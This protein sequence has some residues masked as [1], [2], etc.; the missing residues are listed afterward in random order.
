MNLEAA[1]GEY[2][3]H[4]ASASAVS[5][6][7]AFAGLAA[8]WI[9][10][11]TVAG[12]DRVPSDLVPAAAF[13]VTALGCDLLQYIAATAFWGGFRRWKEWERNRAKE[14]GTKFVDEF[15]AP[16]WIN[17]VGNAFFW[18]KLALVSAGQAVL[19]VG[20][21]RRWFAASSGVCV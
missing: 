19:L 20:I 4:S 15:V 10:K 16:A 3:A 12:V 13:L 17:W 11:V 8:V 9:F 1:K 21:F 7:L 6:Q 2:Y 5:R 18:A 14:S